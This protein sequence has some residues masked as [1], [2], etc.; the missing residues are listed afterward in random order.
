[1]ASLNH[2]NIPKK[3]AD[4]LQLNPHWR[5]VVGCSNKGL[6]KTGVMIQDPRK[7]KVTKL[8]ILFDVEEDV[9]WFQVSMENRGPTVA[10]SVALLQGQHKL[11]HDSQDKS[12]LQ[13]PSTMVKTHTQHC[14]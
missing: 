10:A 13:I 6:C 14:R 8:H 5:H 4:T 9:C 12:L 1:M 3:Q 7:T 2:P 11:C